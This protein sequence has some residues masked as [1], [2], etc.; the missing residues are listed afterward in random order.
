[1]TAIVTGAIA[2]SGNQQRR[3]FV[4]AMLRAESSL[5]VV[6]DPGIETID[7]P[8]SWRCERLAWMEHRAWPTV[9]AN[10]WHLVLE[11]DAVIPVKGFATAVVAA[12]S[13]VRDDCIVSFYSARKEVEAALERGDHWAKYVGKF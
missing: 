10:R 4:G 12:L 2:F 7:P 11:D 8:S 9:T 6:F 1:M 13:A 3:P 5:H